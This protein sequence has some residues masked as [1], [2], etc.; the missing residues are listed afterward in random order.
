LD[1][2]AAAPHHSPGP[3]LAAMSHPNFS[4]YAQILKSLDLTETSITSLEGLP[5]LPRLVSLVLARTSLSSLKNVATVHSICSI[6]LKKTPF[7]ELPHFKLSVIL[8]LGRNLVKIDNCALTALLKGRAEQYPSCAGALI[9]AAW[10]AEYPCPPSRKMAELCDEYHISKPPSVASFGFA[11]K[12]LDQPDGFEPL[13]TD[14]MKQHEQ[15]ML[16]KQALFGIRRGP[17]RE[18]EC[19]LRIGNFFRDRGIAIDVNNDE[20]ILETIEQL[21][22]N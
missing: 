12:L 18:G 4:H 13:A 6:S 2:A 20:A 14:L 8:G 22:I 3:D 21:C 9:N 19:W 16:E 15:L 11:D 10:I 5:A 1:R 7:S 17:A